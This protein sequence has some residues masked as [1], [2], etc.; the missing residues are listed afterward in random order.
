MYDKA[1]K[2]I[3]SLKRDNQYADCVKCWLTAAPVSVE[4]FFRRWLF[5]YASI[6]T[7]WTRNV[8]I[9]NAL[10]DLEWLGDD[11]QLK[12]TLVEHGAGMHN[13]RTKNISSFAADFWTDPTEFYGKPGETWGAYRQRLVERIPGMGMAKTSF[14]LEMTWPTS[15]EVICI[16]THILQLYGCRPGRLSKAKYTEL[17][18]HWVDRCLAMGLAP[19]IARARYWDAKQGYEN[20]H[21]WNY[22]FNDER[23]ITNMWHRLIR[24]LEGLAYV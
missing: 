13:G 16:D 18:K 17:E 20:S 1:E 11:E 23:S 8:I 10:K 24:K 15:A 7:G 9:Y 2:V 3:L 4:D 5:A 19:A 6:Q 14:V 22:V 21:Y 12:S